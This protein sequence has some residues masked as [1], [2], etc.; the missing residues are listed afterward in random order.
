MEEYAPKRCRK[1]TQSSYRSLFKNHIRQRWGAESALNSKTRTVESW[2]EDSPYSRQIKAHVR[3][4]MHTLFQAAIRWEI[5]DRNPI[6][7]V[8]QSRKRLKTPRILTPADFK[9]LLTQLSEPY[10]AIVNRRLFGLTGLRIT[11]SPVGRH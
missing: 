5:L 2:L 11:G 4:L 6:D 1:L 8:R 10:K 7:L 3:N 9:E